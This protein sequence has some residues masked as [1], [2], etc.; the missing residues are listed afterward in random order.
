[1]RYEQYQ[2]QMGEEAPPLEEV[3]DQI[4]TELKNQKVDGI[5]TTLIEELREKRDVEMMV[6][7]PAPQQQTPSQ[8][9][10]EQSQ[11]EPQAEDGSSA[12]EE[13]MTEEEIMEMIEEEQ[14]TEENQQ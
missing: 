9:P 3:R 2:A 4:E 6:E 10:A 12:E 1:E 13:E 14:Q 7:M 8:P 5:L 11:E